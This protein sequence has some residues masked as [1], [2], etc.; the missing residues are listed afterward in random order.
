MSNESV[1][2][3]QERHG[4]RRRPD[5]VADA[6]PHN[7]RARRGERRQTMLESVQFRMVTS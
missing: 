4:L 6:E 2:T 7:L 3:E 5:A 1:E